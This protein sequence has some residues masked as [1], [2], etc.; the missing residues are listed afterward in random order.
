MMAKEMAV[1][2]IKFIAKKFNNGNSGAWRRQHKLTWIVVKKLL[3]NH[4]HSNFLDATIFFTMAFL[5][6]I[7]SW[8]VLDFSLTHQQFGNFYSIVDTLLLLLEHH[9]KTSILSK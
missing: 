2:V 9:Q 1:M 5:H 8:A 4:H 3:L 7:Y 6:T